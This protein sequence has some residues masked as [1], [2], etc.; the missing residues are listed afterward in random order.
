LRGV[1]DAL[2]IIRYV[3]VAADPLS[4]LPDEPNRR[5]ADGK[6]ELLG[7]AFTATLLVA[8]SSYWMGIQSL[9][10]ESVSKLHA[11][12][13]PKTPLLLPQP[14][15]TQPSPSEVSQEERPSSAEVIV[16]ERTPVVVAPI[17]KQKEASLAADPVKGSEPATAI[18]EAV[19]P[20]PE[21]SGERAADPDHTWPV[22]T[23]EGAS[24][25]LVRI[26]HFA[27][28]SEAKKGWE[29]VV[30]QY[31]GMERLKSLPVAI[32]S[33]RNGQLY[34]RLQV[35]TTSQAHSDVVCQRVRD[36]D[37]SCSVIG[38]DEANGESAT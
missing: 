32:K 20:K 21:K 13:V 14:R 3:A 36:M 1:A 18:E 11:S 6:L 33:L 19:G 35:G 25:R 9:K 31:P 29:T 15:T 17:S 22:Q 12:T 38:S 5:P 16:L 26:G 37:Q 27:T 34:Y 28:A 30:R 23:I 8:G 4:C 2:K 7:W 24:G 10:N